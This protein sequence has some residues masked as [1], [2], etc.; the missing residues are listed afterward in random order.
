MHQIDR[1]LTA[2]SRTPETFCESSDVRDLA[3]GMACGAAEHEANIGNG[4]IASIA[5][6]PTADA[7][8]DLCARSDACIAWSFAT[9]NAPVFGRVCFLK[10]IK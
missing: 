6:V 3:V 7:C 10:D 4:H 1:S 9:P 8:C 2:F 5:N